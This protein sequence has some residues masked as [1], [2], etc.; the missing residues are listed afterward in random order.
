MVYRWTTHREVWNGANSN[1][2]RS[3]ELADNAE[4]AD[5]QYFE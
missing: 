1:E 2:V 3:V 4:L 5:V